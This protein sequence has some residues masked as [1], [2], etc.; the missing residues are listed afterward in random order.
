MTPE[1]VK[2]CLTR[3]NDLT[4]AIPPQMLVELRKMIMDRYPTFSEKDVWRGCEAA[5]NREIKLTGQT[6]L[7]G[8]EEVKKE[9]AQ[10]NRA[11]RVRTADKL[12]LRAIE[13]TPR[14]K[15]D[16]KRVEKLLKYLEDDWRK[17]QKAFLES[18]N[19]ESERKNKTRGFEWK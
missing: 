9:N 8:M 15:G 3:L 4:G 17:E 12:L 7:W 19:E 10:R 2:T 16:P 18:E 5:L 6:V 14:T 1:S 13:E 11:E